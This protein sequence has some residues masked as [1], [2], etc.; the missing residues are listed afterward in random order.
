MDQDQMFNLIGRLYTD[1]FAAQRVIEMLQKK[2]QEKEKE[3]I[4][5]EKIVKKDI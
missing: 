1:A 5:L 4:E 3:L 2:L